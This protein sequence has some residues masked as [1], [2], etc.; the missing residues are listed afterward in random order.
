MTTTD[1]LM[2][3]VREGKVS[4]VIELVTDMTTEERRAAV[5]E[6]K[7]LRIELRKELWSNRRGR[8][9][10]PCTPRAPPV[11]PARRRPRRGSPGPRWPGPPPC[12]RCC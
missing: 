10:R 6:L 4:A 1:T 12:P 3:A 11:T 9:V 2:A 7:A 8:S 5:P